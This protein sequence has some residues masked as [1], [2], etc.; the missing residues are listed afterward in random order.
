MCT[1]CFGIVVLRPSHINSAVGT[2]TTT[3]ITALRNE[4]INLRQE[5]SNLQSEVKELKEMVK[6]G[7]IQNIQTSPKEAV[8]ATSPKEAV[9]AVN[10]INKPMSSVQGKPTKTQNDINTGHNRTDLFQQKILQ[11]K[12]VQNH[13]NLQNVQYSGAVKRNSQF[14]S[15]HRSESA[16]TIDKSEANSSLCKR[17]SQFNSPHRSESALTI[18]KSEANSSLCTFTSLRS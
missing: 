5:N 7:T 12:T 2:I 13:N 3:V 6:Q 11:E 9:N 10:M 4:I 8:N 15:P 18:D 16:L 1:L 14:N 17:N